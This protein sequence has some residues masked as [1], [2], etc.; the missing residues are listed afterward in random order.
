M[1]AK[2]NFLLPHQLFETVAAVREH[3]PKYM[4]IEHNLT[5]WS[6]QSA[7]TKIGDDVM[8]NNM[9]KDLRCRQ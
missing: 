3:I 2:D 8:S 1:Q 5:Y 4:T 9:D 7:E 6:S